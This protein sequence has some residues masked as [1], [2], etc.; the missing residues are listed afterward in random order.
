MLKR[1]SLLSLIVAFALPAGAEILVYKIDPVHSGVNFKIRHFLN[2]IPGT[3]T[4]F[5]GEI[6]YDKDNPEN[7]KA[8]AT[9]EVKSV[10]TRNEKRD[11]HLR[12]EDYFAVAEHPTME[13]ASTEWVATG[14]N[15]YL[16]KGILEMLGQSL[17]VELQVTYLGEM[18]GRGTIRSG[19]E[20]TTTLDRS[21][22]GLTS[23]QPVVGLEVDVELNIQAHR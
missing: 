22:W 11:E 5:G 3:F 9:I 12:S 16:V 17:P 2:K 14:E 18:D 23:G 15:T 4:A 1:L 6:H 19:W 10:D 7:C 8:T 13:F 20:A 21:N